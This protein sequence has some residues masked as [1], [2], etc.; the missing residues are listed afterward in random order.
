MYITT[1]AKL[2]G[3]EWGGFNMCSQPLLEGDIIKEC[4]SYGA[5]FQPCDK[6]ELKTIEIEWYKFTVLIQYRRIS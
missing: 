3:K 2:Q 4:Q 5:E 6:G 1:I